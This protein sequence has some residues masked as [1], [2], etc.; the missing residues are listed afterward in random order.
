M[1]LGLFLLTLGGT[2]RLTRLITD[3][4]ITRHIRAF[5]IRHRGPDSDLAYLVTCPFCLSMYIAGGAFSAAWFYGSHPA[6]I[7]TAAALTASWLVGITASILDGG[8]DD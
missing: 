2:I 4:F 5:V 7:I 3:D 8:A 1:S 6:F